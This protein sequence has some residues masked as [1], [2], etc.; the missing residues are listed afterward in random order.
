MSEGYNGEQNKYSPCPKDGSGFIA[1][2]SIMALLSFTYQAMPLGRQEGPEQRPVSISW[3]PRKRAAV[4]GN[5]AQPILSL[6]LAVQRQIYFL[7]NK[8][9]KYIHI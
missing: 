5:L 2:M 7:T 4:H 6:K 3:E 9:R 1:K 8:K